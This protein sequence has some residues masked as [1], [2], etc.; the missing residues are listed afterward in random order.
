MRSHKTA[1]AD[2]ISEAA[3]C[4][5][6][7]LTHNE[8]GKSFTEIEERCG[9]MTSNSAAIVMKALHSLGNKISEDHTGRYRIAQEKNKQQNNSPRKD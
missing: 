4:I 9:T 8:A 6:N 3:G 2:L 7:Y 1:E 5:L